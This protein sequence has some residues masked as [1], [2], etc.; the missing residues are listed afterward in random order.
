MFHN[1]LR[2]A[3]PIVT[4]QIEK[5]GEV[6]A[7]AITTLMS[8]ATHGLNL[9]AYFPPISHQPTDLFIGSSSDV[10]SQ[11][12]SILSEGNTYTSDKV[13]QLLFNIETQGLYDLAFHLI[14]LMQ[15]TYS[16]KAPHGTTDN[17]SDMAV[18][19]Y[20]L[21]H[22]D[23]RVRLAGLRGLHA[24]FKNSACLISHELC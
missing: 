8:F 1:K 20:S 10:V 6:R 5:K 16:G 21:E 19:R 3:I 13:L 4:L 24:R 14:L 18:F 23:E 15:F 12:V 11:I 9:W 2:N 17:A 7:S 22:I